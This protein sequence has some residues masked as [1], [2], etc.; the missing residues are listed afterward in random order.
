M[1]NILDSFAGYKLT[2]DKNRVTNYYYNHPI[3]TELLNIEVI[4]RA[5]NKVIHEY[6][7][8]SLTTKAIKTPSK[9]DRLNSIRERTN[10]IYATIDEYRVKR[11]D[12]KILYPHSWPSG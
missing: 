5:V 12:S 9:V 11:N 1:I 4:S 3:E 6:A 10:L 7:N 8:P 2:L